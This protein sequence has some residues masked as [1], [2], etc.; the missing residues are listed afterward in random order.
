VLDVKHRAEKARIPA[1]QFRR[2]KGGVD[3]YVLQAGPEL[4]D[5]RFNLG[6]SFGHFDG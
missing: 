5:F 3:F 4:C 2:R 1:N 6:T